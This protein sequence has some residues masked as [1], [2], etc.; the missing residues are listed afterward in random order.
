MSSTK[1]KN[2]RAVLLLLGALCSVTT[3]CCTKS[4]SSPDVATQS[5][6]A[7]GRAHPAAPAPRV[8]GCMLLCSTPRHAVN[9]LML[10]LDGANT[11]TT[12]V[13]SAGAKNS[14]PPSPRVFFDTSDL[15][16]NGVA[17]SLGW[18]QLGKDQKHAERFKQIDQWVSQLQEQWRPQKTGPSVR[19][20]R[21]H[22]AR[23]VEKTAQKVIFTY[24]HP[25]G[26]AW[27]FE[28]RRRGIEWLLGQITMTP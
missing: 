16:W 21:Q 23:V 22:K 20:P 17:I 25:N 6:T 9:N 19:P 8:G 1:K 10:A 11:R 7:S 4:R 18:V 24:A 5:P 26:S 13:R 2:P 3:V 15:K 14:L 28:F 27:V 12:G